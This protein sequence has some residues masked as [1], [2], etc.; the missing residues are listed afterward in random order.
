MPPP[1]RSCH[2]G[3]NQEGGVFY[4]RTAQELR[5]CYDFGDFKAYATYEED[6]DLRKKSRNVL[7]QNERVYSRGDLRVRVVEH[8]NKLPREVVESPSVET[9]KTRLDKFLCNLL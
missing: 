7:L 3:A 2:L 4:G 9:F 5:I 6:N 1:A 8:W